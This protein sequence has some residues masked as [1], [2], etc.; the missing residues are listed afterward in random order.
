[1][2]STSLHPA[3][4]T[5]AAGRDRE[6]H[7]ART[8]G[9]VLTVGAL[10]FA[11]TPLLGDRGGQA[12]DVVATMFQVGIW[13]LVATMWRTHATGRSRLAR[14]MLVVEMGLLSLASLASVLMLLPDAIGKSDPVMV[15]DVFWPLSMLGMAVVGVKVAVAGV[16]RGAL[17]C[18]PAVA[19]TWVL[20]VIPS[21]VVF[22]EV[23]G[24][25]VAAAHLMVG[26]AVLG[27]L[28]VLRP[29]LTRG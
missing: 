22:G 10:A 29:D 27:L 23:V 15:L 2:T 18:W 17:R 4:A 21:I 6:L 1:M 19:E 13:F 26:Y 24:G 12:V 14:S 25:V 28:L 16:W 3:T 8:A 5:P 7:R 9:G 11:A 20:F